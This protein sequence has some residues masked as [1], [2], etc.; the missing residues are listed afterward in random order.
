MKLVLVD[1]EGRHVSEVVEVATL[2][3]RMTFKITV[4]ASVVALRV[5]GEAAEL[6]VLK[7]EPPLP[8]NG[9]DSLTLGPMEARQ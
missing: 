3:E 7:I 8:L 4:G 2:G 1:F 6:D 9:T 5:L